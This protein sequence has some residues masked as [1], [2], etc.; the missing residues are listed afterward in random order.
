MTTP[1]SDRLLAPALALFIAAA[2][3]LA[4]TLSFTDFSD[5]SLLT[6]NGSTVTTTTDDGVVLRLTSATPNNSGSAFSSA[7]VNAA[8]FST[9][10]S[11]RITE[12]GG[13]VTDCNGET[14][15]DGLVFVVQSVA[16]DIGGFGGGLGY[17]GITPSVGVEVDTWCNG[18]NNDPNTNHLG[19]DLNGS[20][21]HGPRALDTYIPPATLDNSQIWWMW[22]DYD[23][24]ILEVRLNDADI[25]PPQPVMSKP[26]DIPSMLG[27]QTA[28]VGFTS[29]T[30]GAWGNYDILT[31]E[32]DVFTP[33]CLGDFNGD[34]EIDGKDLGQLLG[35][36]GKDLDFFDLN[37]DDIVDGADLGILLGFWGP[38][39]G[40]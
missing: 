29:G 10:F 25:K 35:D 31:W 1:T 24:G 11:F 7:T 28:F 23:G 15:A 38:C 37:G 40:E 9:K 32:Y 22:V 27:Q 30:G 17:A 6:L 36:W 33:T 34:F 4:G 3:A 21:D 18:E 19:I 5:A 39:P 20:V 8:A 16:S 2:P 13:T 12:P 14:G 26:L